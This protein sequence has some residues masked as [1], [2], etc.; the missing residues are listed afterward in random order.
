MITSYYERSVSENNSLLWLGTSKLI[1]DEFIADQGFKF[2][3]LQL[4]IYFFISYTFF[5]TEIEFDCANL[6]LIYC[7]IWLFGFNVPVKVGNKK[8][9]FVKV[10]CGP[11]TSVSHTCLTKNFSGKTW[12][13]NEALTAYRCC[14][15]L[16]LT[17]VY[18]NWF[19]FVCKLDLSWIEV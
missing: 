8:L 3:A 7:A 18:K 10:S 6:M 1:I 2:D 4:L 9:Q 17:I 12:S 13:I 5:I 11:V 15:H 16:Q 19:D 14:L